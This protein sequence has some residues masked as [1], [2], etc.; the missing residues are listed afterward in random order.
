MSFV[1][2]NRT[3]FRIGDVAQILGVKPYVIRFWESEFPFL[4]PDKAQSGQR[5][6]RRTQIESLIFVKHL[7]HVDR[8]SIEGEKKR[9]TELRRHYKLKEAVTALMTGSTV[10]EGIIVEHVQHSD[11]PTT[12]GIGSKISKE[13][14]DSLQEKMEDLR[15]LIREPSVHGV[16]LPGLKN[17]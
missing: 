13:K 5:V 8:Y 10:S 7:L 2:P 9:L 15:K 14:I 6:Y 11:E 17:L 3:F 1:I 16:P 12:L 4:A